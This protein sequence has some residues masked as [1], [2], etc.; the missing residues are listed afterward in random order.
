MSMWA[1]LEEVWWESQRVFAPGSLPPLDGVSLY[2]ICLNFY[3]QIF[4]VEAH[5]HVPP[6]YA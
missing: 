1:D 5:L 3:Q 2:L 4:E 6:F